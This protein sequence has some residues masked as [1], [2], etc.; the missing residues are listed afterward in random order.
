MTGRP[1]AARP[2][3]GG[4][5]LVGLVAVAAA[6]AAGPHAERAAGGGSLGERAVA[7]R[8]GP[9]DAVVRSVEADVRA[10]FPGTWRW[11]TVFRRPDRYAWTIATL[12]E[13]HH[14]VYDGA[15][16][17]AFVGGREVAVDASPNAP[18]VSHARFTAIANLDA[19]LDPGVVASAL[20]EA[21]LPPGAAAGLRVRDATG[22]VYRLAFDGRLLLV[23]LRG[24][25]SL[26]PWAAGEL[27]AR[28]DDF[29]RV[30]GFVLPFRTTYELGGTVLAEE[31]VL[32]VCPNPPGLDDGA[33]RALARLPNCE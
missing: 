13:P 24:P 29:R 14:Y 20:P 7:A 27:V 12:G 8:G 16:V 26:A 5:V 9:L 3:A 15:A 23:E 11:R 28:Y 33:F 4:L 2:H 19:L 25:V 22:A 1:Q 32:A 17:R 18:L 10:G 30:G 6:C 31:R 21:E